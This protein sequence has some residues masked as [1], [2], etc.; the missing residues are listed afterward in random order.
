MVYGRI[1]ISQWAD[2]DN[3][4]DSEVIEDRVNYFIEQAGIMIDSLLDS[5]AYSVP[6]IDPYP[7]QIVYLTALKA[8]ILLYDGRRVVNDE[9]ENQV[10]AQEKQ[11]QSII[12]RILADTYSLLGVSRKSTKPP[13]VVKYED[14][15]EA[16][17]NLFDPFR[18]ASCR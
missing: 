9:T 2:L 11:F 4:Q 13:K 17:E 15:S 18:E 6:F 8:G 3:D 7:D 12:G 16:A 14:E 5:S 1:N 10:S